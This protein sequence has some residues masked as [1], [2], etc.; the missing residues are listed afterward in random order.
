MKVVLKGYI[1]VPEADLASVTEALAEHIRLTH[2][3]AGCLVFK[4][5]EDSSHPG[6]FQVYEEF[7]DRDSFDWHQQR[8][9]ASRWGQVSAN[10]ARH[11]QITEQES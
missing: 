9:K 2:E 3:E 1:D 7:S 8:V 6:R 10:V 5:T 4:V 11:Y